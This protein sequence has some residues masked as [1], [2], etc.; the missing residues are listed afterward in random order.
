MLD[1]GVF[2][3]R[4]RCWCS[5]DSRNLCKRYVISNPLIILNQAI[6]VYDRD[7]KNATLWQDKEL[8]A[9]LCSF[10]SIKPTVTGTSSQVYRHSFLHSIPSLSRDSVERLILSL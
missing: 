3:L 10:R 4:N 1:K 8:P 5:T 9:G 7:V 2:D 6:V